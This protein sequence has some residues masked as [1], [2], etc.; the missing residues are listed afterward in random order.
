MTWVPDECTLPTADQPLRVR[1]F[2]ALFAEAVDRV[3][4]VSPDVLR[5]ELAPG[6]GVAARVADL[7]E[8]ETSCCSFFAFTLT[9][10]GSGLRLDVAVPG[11]RS[12]ILDALASRATTS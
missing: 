4:R 3:E 7:V 9:A 1:E 11:K 10:D 2:D 6:A 12:D 8:R 5:F